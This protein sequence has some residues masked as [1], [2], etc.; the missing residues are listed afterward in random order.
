MTQATSSAS[1]DRTIVST[2]VLPFTREQIFAAIADPQRLARWW[3]PAGFRNTFERFD[4]R[5]GGEWKYTMHGPD[6]QDYPNHVRFDAI[7]APQRIVLHHVA[8]HFTLHMALTEQPGGTQ[9]QWLQVFDDARVRDQ[10]AP[11][12]VPANEQNFDRLH[13]ELAHHS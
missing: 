6:G 8:P 11:I 13:A 12:C 10:L 9:L 5:P 7:E 2:R 3:G 4:F 1:A